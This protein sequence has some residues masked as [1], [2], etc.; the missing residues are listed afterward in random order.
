[1]SQQSDMA[2]AIHARLA[3][4]PISAASLVR[5]LRHRWGPDHGINYV[6]LFIVEVICCLLR[7]DDVE[8]GELTPAGPVSWGLP[9]EDSYEKIESQLLAMPTWLEDDTWCLFWKKPLS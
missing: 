9:P 4:G 8:V 5:E 1:M 2:D 6:H 7:K 3:S